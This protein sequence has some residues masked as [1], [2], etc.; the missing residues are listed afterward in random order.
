LERSCDFSQSVPR[1]AL[2]KAPLFYGRVLT[3]NV[4]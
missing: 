3:R 4:C 2:P 1:A